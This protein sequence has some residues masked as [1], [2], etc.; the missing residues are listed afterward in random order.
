MPWFPVDNTS[1]MFKLRVS[2]VFF[3]PLIVAAFCPVSCSGAKGGA[4]SRF[5]VFEIS[6]DPSGISIFENQAE[7]DNLIK[8]LQNGRG[9][10][11]INSNFVCLVSFEGGVLQTEFDFES[12]FKRWAL[13][14]AVE[15]TV[16]WMNGY[17]MHLR[18]LKPGEDP[19]VNQITSVEDIT[20]C[21]HTLHS[22]SKV[23]FPDYVEARPRSRSNEVSE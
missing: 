16:L 22:V 2:L 10:L 6:S 1:K 5:T 12:D 3:V 13:S 4:E 9:H 15:E 8:D 23:I 11:E 18:P 17:P 19:L 20:E 14:N 7:W 21:I